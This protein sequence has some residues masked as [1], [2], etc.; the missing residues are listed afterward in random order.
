[1]FLLTKK[2][3]L[4]P[5]LFCGYFITTAQVPLATHAE[6]VIGK[7]N[8]STDWMLKRLYAMKGVSKATAVSLNKSLGAQVASF[9][10]MPQLN[11]P[12]GFSTV[13]FLGTNP[14]VSPEEALAP[15][16]RVHINM[17]Y[18]NRYT[19]TGII[20]VSMDGTGLVFITNGIRAFLHQQGNFWEDCNKMKLP[21][22]F[23]QLPVTDSTADYI[24]LNFSMAGNNPGEPIR[25]IKRN[26]KPLFVPY[27]RK[28]FLQY[29]VARENY[30][31]NDTRKTIKEVQQR[32]EE[33]K[34]NASNPASQ[35]IKAA[36][37][38]GVTIMEKQIADMNADIMVKQTRLA[39]YRE[40]QDGMLPV[41]GA[42]GVRLDERKKSEELYGL[43]QVVPV[44]RYEGTALYKINPGYFDRSPG[45]PGAQ[46]IIVYY[47]IPH[48]SAFVTDPDYLQRK[49][50]EIF[51]QL[52]YHGLKES[53]Q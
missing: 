38:N 23:E 48:A 13:V 43:E 20:K 11:P 44:G 28:E 41:E 50:V 22:F 4:L 21:L 14:P 27:T 36:L 16:A 39:H 10:K 32:I 1:M 31:I 15:D 2:I 40:V 12:K 6:D 9:F 49:T 8:T 26:N 3:F 19:K 25:I 52:D 30:R 47:D 7:V 33:A 42:A 5:L 46:L 53:M 18:M 34:R 17:Y 37:E 35:S 29:L 51:N 45:A 24:E